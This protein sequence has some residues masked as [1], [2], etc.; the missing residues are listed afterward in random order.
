MALN[1]S[2]KS[3]AIAYVSVILL[4][5]AC[6]EPDG[7]GHACPIPVPCIVS[8]GEVITTGLEALKLRGAC[9][10]GI[11]ACNELN[12]VDRCDGFVAATD[13]FC[14][15][16]DNDCDGLIDEGFDSDVDGYT[17]C[18]GDCD[19]TTPFINPDAKEL[20]DGLDN[21]CDGVIDAFYDVCWTGPFVSVFSSQ[22]ICSKGLAFCSG[23]I[24]GQCVGQ[25]LP[26]HEVCDGLDNDCNGLTDE[27]SSGQCG[28]SN[29]GACHM[30]DLIC[31]PEHDRVCINAILPTSEVCNG[32][33]DDCNGF[34]DDGLFRRCS[35]VCGSGI[36]HCSS[37][38]WVDCDAPT[39]VAELC[40]GIDNDCNG[41]VDEG[42]S[43]V[44][45]DVM[46][47]RENVIDRAT[48]LPTNCGVG[49]SICDDMGSW[50]PC[51]FLT[52]EPE[53]CDSVDNDCDGLID[54][55]AEQCGDASTAGVGECRMGSKMCDFGTWTQCAGSV[56]PIAEVCNHRDDDCDGLIDEEL[57]PHER[58]DI[59]FFID[60]SGSMCSTMAALRAGISA[61]ATDFIGS[62]HRFCLGVFPGVEPSGS[63]SGIPVLM[64][65][66]SQTSA[67]VDITE[68]QRA[69][70]SLDCSYGGL[71][72]SYDVGWLAANPAD[73][74]HIGWRSP[75]GSNTGAYPYIIIITDEPAQT[76]EQTT[77]QSRE[78]IVAQ[79]MGDCR[80]G[81]C[82][83]GDEY[84]TY[85][86]TPSSFW[87]MWND[88]TFNEQ[89]RLI[90]LYPADPVRYV[91]V[92]RS[93]FSNVC[94]Q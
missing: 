38:V 8:D 22:S 24:S 53:K 43:C 63:A 1:Q 74:L 65:T 62:E 48:G 82:A 50:G 80:V 7:L 4:I 61:Y 36:E 85:V 67:L 16:L 34:I 42:C 25:R 26:E 15:G 37:G 44:A 17:A 86:I 18:S 45:D 79:E 89:S 91:D 5:S 49:V 47:C 46:L 83:Q 27:T 92:L 71:E 35:T 84:E 58:V 69:L 72:P 76:W 2:K 75:M 41:R 55:Y 52:T 56:V 21:D 90:D 23:G 78:T 3:R 66:G 39:P 64:L 20:C 57:N 51:Y 77:M 9:K 60:G 88:I 10:M 87:M 11:T 94:I 32:S 6:S 14:D 40:D 73:P 19:D 31:T 81:S 13:E 28:T 29:I 93:V 30:G 54:G 33:D 68:F 59:C 12:V 70:A